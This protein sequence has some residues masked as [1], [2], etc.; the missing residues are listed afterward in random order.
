[1]AELAVNATDNL[2][3]LRVFDNRIDGLLRTKGLV[4]R[5]VRADT[6]LQGRTHER[7]DQYVRGVRVFGGDLA[8]QVRGGVTESIFGIVYDNV[9]IDTVPRLSETDAHTA[10]SSMSPNGWPADRR[11]ELVVLPK[12][13]GQFALAWR[14]HA[15]PT[16]RTRDT[17]L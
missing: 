4:L 17:C 15:T 6:L 13:D 14:T 5:T 3:E 11:I 7:Y 9:A 1:M 16:G 8:R 2:S 10:F 12:D